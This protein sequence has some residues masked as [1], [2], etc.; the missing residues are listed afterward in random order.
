MNSTGAPHSEHQLVVGGPYPPTPTV[1]YCDIGG[2]RLDRDTGW[3]L[4][5]DAGRCGW[6]ASRGAA[7]GTHA[8]QVPVVYPPAGQTADQ[9]GRAVEAA[10]D[11]EQ[12]RARHTQRVAAI[13]AARE[14][15]G[16]EPRESTTAAIDPFELVRSGQPAEQ[17]LP[18]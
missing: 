16:R 13:R 3:W 5:A 17:P 2:E 9:Y 1:R 11:R 18:F 12:R 4:V 6:V 8:G 14:Q 15:R 7:C 10:Q